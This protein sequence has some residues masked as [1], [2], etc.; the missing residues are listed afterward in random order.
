MSLWGT[1]QTQNNCITFIQRRP[2]VFDAGPTLYKCYTN[3]LCLLG[4]AKWPPIGGWLLI[5]V[6]A[7]SRFYCNINMYI[8]RDYHCFSLLNVTRRSRQWRLSRLNPLSPRDA[9][10]HHFTSLKADFI[11][12]Q[13][14]VFEWKFPWNW[15]TNT[16]YFS[17]IVRPL[18]IIFIHYKHDKSTI[19]RAI[20]GF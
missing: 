16:R 10:K 6:A 7:H 3:V 11:F 4:M 19:A 13:L 14:G 20:R 18:Q 12:L 1:Q 15:F 9:L 8:C 2:N 17:L 5:R